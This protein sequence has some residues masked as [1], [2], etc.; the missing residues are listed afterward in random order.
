MQVFTCAACGQP[1]YFENFVCLGCNAPLGF[2]PD[3][4]VLGTLRQD[5]PDRFTPF[6]TPAPVLRRCG[7]AEAGYCNWMVPEAGPDLCTACALNRTIPDLTPENR[8]RWQ[9]VET[10]RR[11]L[12]YALLR[13]R[14]PVD[15][16][17][18]G[19]DVLAERPS[20]PPVMTGHAEGLVTL[21]L[22]EADPAEREKRREEM[23]EPYRSLVGHL[24]HEIGH[25]YWDLLVRDGGRLEEARQVFGDER[26]DYATALERDYQDGP[27][28]AWAETHVSTY[29][30]SHPWEDFAETWAHCLHI[31]DTLDTAQ[32]FRIVVAPQGGTAA[33]LEP[34]F[35]AYAESDMERL[36]ALWLP[37]TY[38]VNSLNRSMG[39][40]D[41]YPFVLSP[42]VIAKLGFVRRLIAG[43]GLG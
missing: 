39:Q 35:D 29:A 1:L 18:L 10:A 33:E 24:R 13:L 30:T 32:S 28:A 22:V 12:V 34:G 11:R 41:L 27:P 2:I 14:L 16:D 20:A 5:R 25:F 7:N 9:E 42:A 17:R 4:G 26:A 38:A 19:F 6:G 3:Q 21:A 8:A 23:G 40:P 31:I 43:A 36:I 37:L 15:P